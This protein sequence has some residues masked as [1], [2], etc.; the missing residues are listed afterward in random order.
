MQKTFCLVLLLLAAACCGQ[1]V[2]PTQIKAPELRALQQQYMDDLKRVG[3]DIA[4]NHFEYG[5]YL[6]RKLDIDEQQQKRSD[7]ASIRFDRF[8]GHTVLA[9]TGNY[10]AAYPGIRM[11]DGQRARSTFLRV[12]MPLLQAAV[13]HFQ[14]NAAVEGYALEISHHVIGAVMRVPVERAENLVVYLPQPA[15]AR[16]VASKDEAARQA[17][18]LEGQMLLNGVPLNIWLNGEGPRDVAAAPANAAL[19]TA[20]GGSLPRSLAAT[21]GKL[22]RA[23][24]ADVESLKRAPA[25]PAPL[26]DARDLSDEA[27]A[28]LQSANQD[29]L[30]RLVK[31]VEPQAHFVAYAPPKFVVFRK[32]IYLAFSFNTSLPA[33]ATASRYQLAALAFDEHVAHLVRPVLGYFK[34]EQKFDGISLSTTVHGAGKAG[35]S[36]SGQAVEF[37][38][39][40]PALHCYEAYDCTGQQLL[41]AGTILINGERVG[42]DLQAAE[43]NP[44]GETVATAH[45]PGRQ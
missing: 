34:G 11:S 5:F 29:N 16:L 17:A 39:P 13:P 43:A 15:A 37:F 6:S 12:A 26:P 22:L 21:E 20:I 28:S 27:L 18:L 2:S 41:D 24:M 32:A 33:P 44:A 7:Q 38:F 9:I 4:A 36:S 3:E 25:E 45:R 42:L 35:T 19:G 30:D 31:E 8:N 14:S 10:Y 23:S 1:V 40:L